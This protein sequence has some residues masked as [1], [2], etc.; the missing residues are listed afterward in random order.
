MARTAG[1]RH[2]F[3]GGTWPLDPLLAAESRPA[4][5]RPR[6]PPVLGPGPGPVARPPSDAL[7]VARRDAGLTRGD[8]FLRYF[9]LGGMSSPLE[10]E[11]FCCGALRPSAHD[12]D[13]IAHALNERFSELGRD[14][15]VGY[16][17]DREDDR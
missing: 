4:M 7:D 8:L 10:L 15:P 2:V 1:P 14:H 12:H 11:A 17:A 6:R 3:G 16:D 5:R 9:E 13:V